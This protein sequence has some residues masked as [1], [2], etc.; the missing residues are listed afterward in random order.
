MPRFIRAN[1]D[2][3]ENAPATASDCL[4]HRCAEHAEMPPVDD[5]GDD[6][7]ECGVCVGVKFVQ[8]HEAA[9]EDDIKKKLYWPMVQSARDRL[10][11]LAA[12]AGDAFEEEARRHVTEY[13]KVPGYEKE[14]EMEKTL[15]EKTLGNTDVEGAKKN[16]RDLVVLGDGNMFKL[17]CKASSQREGWMKSTKAMEID[18]VGCVVQVTTHQRNIDGTNSVAE[19]LTFVPSTRIVADIDGGRKLVH[20]STRDPA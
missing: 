16:V 4:A 7:S 11:L 15:E 1:P 8:A 13:D 10:N 14:T 19:A 3:D 9:A 5:R 6:G 20:E 18:G 12:G 2:R 17:L